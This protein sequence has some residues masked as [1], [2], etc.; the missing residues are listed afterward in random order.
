MCLS[1][2]TV[3]LDLLCWDD[4]REDLP[5][6]ILGKDH[7]KD[8]EGDSRLASVLQASYKSFEELRG[9]LR[10]PGNVFLAKLAWV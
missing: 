1:P 8:Q 2:R 6:P 10:R 9:R 5:V 4:G 3:A 7:L